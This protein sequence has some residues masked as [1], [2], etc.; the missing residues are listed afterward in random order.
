MSLHVQGICIVTVHA[1]AGSGK[2]R[3]REDFFV[4]E[5]PTLLPTV[6]MEMILAGDFKCMLN[7]ADSTGHKNYS[8]ALQNLITNID[9][10]DVWRPTNQRPGYTYYGPQTASRLDRI[11]VTKEIYGRKMAVEILA[12]AFRSS[13]GN[14]LHSLTDDHTDKR[15][16]ILVDERVLHARGHME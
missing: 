8:T 11:Y 4:T 3:E 15:T 14:T 13:C 7:N 5:V 16:W 9:L 1:P 12:P 6:P 2:R 10:H